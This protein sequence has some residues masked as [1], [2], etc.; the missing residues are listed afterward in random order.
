MLGIIT[1]ATLKLIPLP[2]FRACLAI[3]FGSMRDAIRALHAIFQAG[4]LPCALEVADAF[5]LAAAFNRTKSERLRGCRAHLI[6]EL[7]GQKKSV[8]WEI[9]DLEKN[10]AAP[11]AAV[12]RARV[13]R[14]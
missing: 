11:P 4:F 3:G 5:T 8:Q 2:P 13:G 10:R 1:E 14:S 7:D 12:C 6:V 9:R